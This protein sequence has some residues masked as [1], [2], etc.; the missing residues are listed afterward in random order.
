MILKVFGIYDSKVKAY[1]PPF[2]MKSIG[3]AERA[4]CEH[5]SDVNHNFCK[6][7]EDFTLFELGSW[8]DS[9]AQYTLLNTPH[10]LGLLLEYKKNS[11]PVSS[12]TLNM[13]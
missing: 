13:V 3:E 12:D 2:M 7:S 5:V 11:T 1:L 6:Y 8:D 10:S 4:L 9:N